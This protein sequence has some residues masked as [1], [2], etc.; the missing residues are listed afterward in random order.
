MLFRGISKTGGVIK[1]SEC[2]KMYQQFGV[3]YI[4]KAEIGKLVDSSNELY[5][6]C[7]RAAY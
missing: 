7:R 4:Q 3:F 5:N 6:F 2:N 1:G